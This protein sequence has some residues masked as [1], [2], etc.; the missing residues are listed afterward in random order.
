MFSQVAA[1]ARNVLVSA[2][3]K[4]EH[5]TTNASASLS[6]AS[7]NGVSVFPTAATRIPEARIIAAAMRVVVVLPSVPVTARMGRGPP[8]RDC[9]QRYANS[10]SDNIS[11]CASMEIANNGWV[12][13]TPGAGITLSTFFTKPASAPRSPAGKISAPSSRPSCSCWEDN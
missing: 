13:G 9:S 7:M 5:S 12:S 2:N 1:F 10:I 6:R 11:F 8:L 3:R 4:L